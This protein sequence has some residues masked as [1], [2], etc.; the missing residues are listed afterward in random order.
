MGAETLRALA[1]TGAGGIVHAFLHAARSRRQPAAQRRS[2]S[3]RRSTALYLGL[4]RH[5]T[6]LVRVVPE[7]AERISF[8]RF[9]GRA[10]RVLAGKEF[11]GVEASEY[12]AWRTLMTGGG[13]GILKT[14]NQESGNVG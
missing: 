3:P 7:L 1:L 2:R 5:R 10:D 13:M 6:L 14:E 11:A 9:D 8:H 12:A 4:P